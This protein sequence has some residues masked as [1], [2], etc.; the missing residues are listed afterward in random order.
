VTDD[1]APAAGRRA[2]LL[3]GVGLVVVGLALAV[4]ALVLAFGD[5]S[6]PDAGAGPSPTLTPW[7]AAG[8]DPVAYA[9]RLVTL[10]NA[11]RAAQGVPALATA[12]CATDQA[13]TRAAALAGGKPLEH[14]PMAPVM[15]ACAVSEAGENLARGAATPDDVMKAWMRSPGHR[16][17][18]L[19]ATYDAVG[20]ACRLDDAQMLCSQVFLGH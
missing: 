5:R 4:V 2:G 3:L 20:V 6:H 16:S 17:N 15:A 12:D 10:T 9:A 11:E 8:A 7:T 14:A 13:A 19:D 1:D 18:I